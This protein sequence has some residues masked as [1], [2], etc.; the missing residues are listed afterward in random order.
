MAADSQREARNVAQG[1]KAAVAVVSRWT[2]MPR[3]RR[4]NQSQSLPGYPLPIVH[5]ERRLA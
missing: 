5:I 2:R 4:H 3:C 1:G